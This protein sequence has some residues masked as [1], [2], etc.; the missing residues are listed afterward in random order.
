MGERAGPAGRHVDVALPALPAGLEPLIA[1]GRLSLNQADTLSTAVKPTDW[2]ALPDL[3]E[4]HGMSAWLAAAL[5]RWTGVPAAVRD[6]VD[7]TVRTQAAHALRGLAELADVTA[8]L[9]EAEIESVVLKG[10][11]LSRWLYGDVGARRFSD[12]D[13][14]VDRKSRLRAVEVLQAAGYSLPAGMTPAQAATVYAGLKAWPLGH[15]HAIPLDLHWRPQASRFGSAIETAEILRDSISTPVAGRAVR[16]PQPT[17]AA[18]LAVVHAAKHLWVSLELLLSVAH[19]SAR[20][21]VDW[22]RVRALAMR[23]GAWNGAAASLVL[24]SEIF[25]RDLP[26]AL[27]GLPLPAS[28]PLL[29]TCA[30]DFLTMRDVEDT[31]WRSEWRAHGM[32]LDTTVRRLRYTAL[33]VFEPTPLDWSWCPL[34]DAFAPLYVGVRLLRLTLAGLRSPITRR[35][36][37]PRRTAPPSSKERTGP[38]VKQQQ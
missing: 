4:R 28:V 23:A 31:S 12:L 17:H 6:A 22:L 10:P 3:A 38:R 32:S 2:L 33:R 24:A 25:E 27:R 9:D 21:D 37:T 8:R 13:L 11:L 7:G 20:A 36:L 34:P 18:T 15:S 16:I 14:L 29:R 35:T 19:L 30:R 26:P 5:A 1:A